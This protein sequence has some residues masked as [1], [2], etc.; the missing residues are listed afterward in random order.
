MKL[1]K[2]LEKAKEVRGEEGGSPEKFSPSTKKILPPAKKRL[3]GDDWKPPVYSESLSRQLDTK[4]VLNNR[5]VCIAPDAPQLDSYKV[6]RTKIHQMS[7]EKGWN[8]VM[9]T[10]PHAGEGKTLTSINLALTFSKAYNQTVL[11][12]D[13]DLRNQNVHRM[14]GFESSFGLIDYLIDNKP[15]QEFIIWPGIE[16]LTLISGGRTIHDSTELLGSERMKTLV[17]E[18]KSR[19]KDRYVLFDVAPVLVGADALALAPYVDGIVMVVE[20]GRTSMRDVNKALEVLPQ[21]KFLGFVMNREK[22]TQPKKY[23]YYPGG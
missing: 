3:P 8:S 10:S 19:Y 1:R 4:T 22:D 23:Q 11:L 15:L 7:R 12:V 16:K 5:C 9:I 13:C 6:L 17:Q 18:L 2:A 21:E 20:Q 14:L